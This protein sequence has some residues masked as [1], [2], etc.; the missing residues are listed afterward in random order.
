ME[1]RPSAQKFLNLCAES[2][3]ESATDEEQISVSSATKRI[4]GAYER[5]RNILEPEEIDILRRHAIS[6]VLYRRVSS[7]SAT[8]TD[9]PPVI[10]ATALL[11]ELI[12]GGYIEAAS[13]K[14]AIA[15]SQKIIS[16]RQIEPGLDADLF[17]WLLNVVAISIDRLIYPR[18]PEESLVHLMYHDVY[19]RT[20]WTD[21][22]VAEADRPAQLFVGCHRALFAAA[23]EEIIYHYFIHHFSAWSKD[24]PLSAEA[25]NDLV[26]QLPKFK[27][28]V[29]QIVNHSSAHRVAT[30]LKPVAVPYRIMRQLCQDA[31][32][33]TETSLDSLS[34]NV[35]GAIQE[36][37]GTII[38]RISARARHSVLFLLFTKTILVFLVEVP[39]ERFFLKEIHWGA[40]IAN[41]LFHPILLFFLSATVR[42]PSAD[43]VEKIIEQVY[44][45]IS[46]DGELPT[47]VMQAP[48]QYGALTW[49]TFGLIYTVLFIFIFWLLTFTLDKLGFSLLAIFFFVFYLG[50]VSFLAMRNRR[51]VDELRVLPKHESTIGVITS[52][53]FLPVLEFGGLLSRT[54]QRFNIPLFLMDRILEAPFKL[55]IDL[56]EEW[57]VF[58]RERREEIV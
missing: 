16:L 31:I 7:A 21:N 2:L 8:V 4:A 58:I 3:P 39:Y 57:F 30:I 35:R 22:L 9:D 51:T 54:L 15:I 23:D 27:S 45:I 44:K 41:T 48:R 34:N 56:V 26:H 46:G 25:V 20:T 10:V 40:L 50:L 12:R 43:N 14:L 18:K 19:K 38:R 17:R 47:I 53:I 24:Q 28:D 13:N 6:R 29:D 42:L 33:T 11:Q 37:G 49:A 5:F 36:K 55:L 1:I 32:V 52:F